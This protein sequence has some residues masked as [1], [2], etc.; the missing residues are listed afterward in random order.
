MLEQGSQVEKGKCILAGGA[1]GKFLFFFPTTFIST[2]TSSLCIGDRFVAT[3]V[4]KELAFSAIS[5]ARHRG[6]DGSIQLCCLQLDA[7]CGIMIDRENTRS[8]SPAGS[9]Y[10][11]GIISCGN[12]PQRSPVP[13]SLHYRFVFML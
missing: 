2:I 5:D 11:S 13:A 7:Y 6:L 4:V 1:S 9:V 8:L 12:P 10:L 3:P